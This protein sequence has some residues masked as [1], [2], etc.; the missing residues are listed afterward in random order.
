MYNNNVLHMILENED[1]ANSYWNRTFENPRR[2]L[3]SLDLKMS[4]LDLDH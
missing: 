1:L 2:C 3:A 4:I